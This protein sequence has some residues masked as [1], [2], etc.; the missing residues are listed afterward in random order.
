[1]YERLVGALSRAGVATCVLLALVSTAVWYLLYKLSEL[2]GGTSVPLPAHW[3]ELPG[4]V[5]LWLS[6]TVYAVLVLFRYLQPRNAPW[7]P[8]AVSFAGALSYWAGVQY[9]VELRP[10]ESWVVDAAT[11]GVMTAAFLG[12]L[13]IRLGTLQFTLW[14][15][16]ALCVAGALGGALIGWANP[17]HEPVFVAG[18]ATW[19]LLTCV[20]L[21]YS[22]RSVPPATGR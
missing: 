15:F 16:A 20:A 13:L 18:H 2:A 8:V 17:R 10:A 7:H 5:L 4:W 21:Y 9:T 19:Q 12:Y 22:P 14:P 3:H 6:G 11:A 1:M